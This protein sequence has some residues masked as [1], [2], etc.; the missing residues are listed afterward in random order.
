MIC[1]I[2]V[3][4]RITIITLFD[5]IYKGNVYS[6]LI[7]LLCLHPSFFTAAILL[8]TPYLSNFKCWL[9]KSKYVLSCFCFPGILLMQYSTILLII[10]IFFK[11]FAHANSDS[12][13]N[14]SFFKFNELS[15]LQLSRSWENKLTGKG[16]DFFYSSISTQAVYA[17]FHIQSS[18][19]WKIN[20][21]DCLINMCKICHSCEWSA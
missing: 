3:E 13:C 4:E 11:V 8:L 21:H 12:V 20:D 14:G 7:F 16:Y 9:S 10:Y 18:L 19:L 5:S 17:Q 6:S 2:N 1:Y 15:W